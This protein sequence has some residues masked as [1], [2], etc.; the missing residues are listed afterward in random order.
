MRVS[1]CVA[2]G[3]RCWR[4]TRLLDR[5]PFASVLG[6]LFRSTIPAAAIPTFPRRL[7]AIDVPRPLILNR[8]NALKQQRQTGFRQK[9]RFTARCSRYR[10][11]TPRELRANSSARHP[12]ATE[13][14]HARERM[15]FSSS[16]S[17]VYEHGFNSQL[18]ATSSRAG[19]YREIEVTISAS[20][21]T[22]KEMIPRRR[23]T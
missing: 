18:D 8:L 5:V 21:T 22:G 13:R 17:I 10:E 3:S 6:H 2:H 7:V 23:D 1:R 12:P 11:P 14:V 15:Y 16:S 19:C 9:G 4:V 20:E